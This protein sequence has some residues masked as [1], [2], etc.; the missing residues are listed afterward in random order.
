MLKL[1]VG[2]ELIFAD[3]PFLER[4]D[5]V[6]KAG[7]PA[8][9]FWGWRD[10]ELDAIAERV[11]RHGLAVPNMSL[12][13]L[14]CILKPGTIPELERAVRET[15]AAARKVGC[16]RIT[17][18]LDQLPWGAGE[19]WYRSLTS[20]AAIAKRKRQREYTVKALKAVVP[21][22]DGEGTMIL[23]EPVNTLV[24]HGGYFLA[25]SDEAAGIINEVDHAAV[26]LLFDVYHQQ[27]TEGNLINNITRYANLIA[28]MHVADAPGR[29]E[30]GTGEINFLN[31]LRAA[32]RAGYDGYV[33]L[34]YSPATD[35]RASMKHIQSILEQVN[36][37]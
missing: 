32:R 18:H 11:K 30:P 13:P 16:T 3:R 2:V 29:H 10:K 34:E 23:L 17:A 8:F 35:S 1:S 37:E 15:A 28:H 25:S 14:V 9:E 31:V 36:R 6:A 5:A 20:T 4:I 7:L 27:I 12:D 22:A 33:G 26:R 24:D 21:V 19:P